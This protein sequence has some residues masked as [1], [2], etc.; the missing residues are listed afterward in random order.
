MSLIADRLISDIL[1]KWGRMAKRDFLLAKFG[2]NLRR[3]RNAAA[4]TQEALAAKANMD[5]TY[6]SDIERG[7]RNPGIKNVARLAN[8]LNVTSAE[9]ME[10]VDE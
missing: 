10:G 3:R 6:I 9:L 8:A 4:L 2:R 5:R 7:V 1:L